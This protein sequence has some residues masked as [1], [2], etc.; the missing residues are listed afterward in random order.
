MSTESEPIFARSGI[1]PTRGNQGRLFSRITYTYYF[2]PILTV[3]TFLFGKWDQRKDGK[4]LS[5]RAASIGAVPA[6][7]SAPWYQYSAD[8]LILLGYCWDGWNQLNADTTAQ[9]TAQGAGHGDYCAFS[10][11]S[12]YGTSYGTVIPT[13]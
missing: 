4:C 13:Q 2:I 7:C 3:A 10:L 11:T 8:W 1:E 6:P 9:S 5:T 12:S